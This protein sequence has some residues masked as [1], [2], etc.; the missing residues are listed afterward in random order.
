MDELR[1]NQP[2]LKKPKPMKMRTRQTLHE[3][4]LVFVGT[5]ALVF[6]VFG[7]IWAIW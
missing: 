7:L 2:A 5:L 4:R 3:D 1:R 6:V